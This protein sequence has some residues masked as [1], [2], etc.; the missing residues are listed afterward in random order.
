MRRTRTIWCVCVSA[1]CV[2]AAL[3]AGSALGEPNRSGAGDAKQRSF[4]VLVYSRTTGFRHLSIAKGI[5]TV[6]ELGERHG[7]RVDATE[8]AA[9]FRRAKLER[10]AA[11]IFLNTT[12]N[13]LD[14]R[15]QRAFRRYIRAGG[16]Y[17]G[18][19]SAADTEHQWPFYGRLAGAYFKSHPVQQ[20]AA[21]DNEAPDHPATEHFKDRMTIFDEHYTF[22][23]NP[24][25]DVR[26]LLTID[27]STYLPNPN[28]SRLPGGSP[29]SG[30]MGDH[31]MSWCHDNLGG[32]AFYTAL[33]HEPH[34]YDQPW[35]RRHVL[36]GILTAAKRVKA[37]CSSPRRGT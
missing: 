13:V 37:G 7:F 25:P 9:R 18:I 35:Y 4:K 16:G 2:A 17:V 10:Y 29:S 27:E 6:R 24:R 19:H 28:T 26:V 23:R 22:D 15:R 14:K 8:N 34:L 11:V 21:F 36:N 33:G 1:A 12:G 3:L 30:Y 31:P 32:R 20:F 5:A